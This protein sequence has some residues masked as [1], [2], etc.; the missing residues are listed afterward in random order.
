MGSLFIKEYNSIVIETI[1]SYIIN[2]P[3][4][5]NIQVQIYD[6]KETILKDTDSNS[7]RVGKDKFIFGADCTLP[8]EIPYER[9]MWIKEALSEV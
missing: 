5:V 8:T 6:S 4:S 9:L 1:H 2:I 3:D 7:F